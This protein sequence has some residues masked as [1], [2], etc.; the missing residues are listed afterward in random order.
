M[1]GRAPLLVG[2]VLVA[3]TVSLVWFISTTS[4]DKYGDDVTYVVYAD[5]S[6]AS[7]IR[8][9]TRVQINGIDVGKIEAIEH[10]RSKSGRLL[11]RV[12]LRILS[13]YELYEN[14]KLRKAAESLLG[15]FRLDL[16]PGTPDHKRLPPGG[17]IKNV[18]SISDLEEI[19]VQLKQVAKNVNEVTES[20]RNVLAGP[21]GEGSLKE[22]MSSVERSMDAI[23]R[24]TSVL[25]KNEQVLDQMIRDLGAFSHALAESTAAGGDI[26]RLAENLTH[27][28]N[29]MADVTDAIGE[30]VAA[31]TEGLPG[32]EGKGSLRN[33]VNELNESLQHLNAIARKIDQGQGTVGRLVND[34]ATAEKVDQTLDDI[35]EVVGPISRMQTQIEL[36]GE[37]AMPMPTADQDQVPPA[38]KNTIGVRIIPKPDKYYLIEAVADPRGKHERTITSTT[39]PAGSD[40]TST[41]ERTVIAYDQLK[42]S[43][44]LAKRYYFLTLRFGLIE[45]SGGLGAD[46]H[47]AD[48]HLELRFDAFDFTRR[49]PVDNSAFFPRLRGRAMF[50]FMRHLWLQAGIDD[51]LNEDLQTW[52]LGGVLRFTDDDLKALFTVA[53][54]P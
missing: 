13:E 12:A 19:Q 37:Y 31:D 43:A 4:K 2:V 10:V 18:Q 36:R 3:A 39:E 20:F 38:I 15:D 22:I 50:E 14:A 11:A 24:A 42:F 41:T 48:D 9:K 21:T 32:E 35:S 46:V 52:F 5:F 45:N 40:N 44:Q 53:P 26:K 1:S 23:E 17:V 28:S 27:I 49:D 54:S 7:G 25:G 30:M 6:D 47:A 33:T 29:R 16:D 51:P 34:P 8:W